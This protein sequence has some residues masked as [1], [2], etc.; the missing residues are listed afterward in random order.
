MVA[1]PIIAATLWRR[2][3]VAIRGLLGALKNGGKML[4]SKSRNSSCLFLLPVVSSASSSTPT[5]RHC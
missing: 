2:M 5:W 3:I 4:F 1:P